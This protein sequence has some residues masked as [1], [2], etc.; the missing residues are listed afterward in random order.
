LTRAAEVVESGRFTPHALD[1]DAIAA[2]DDPL[3]RL[4]AVF[5]GMAEEIYARERRLQRNLRTLQ[6]SLLVL[7]VGA[8]WGLA[9]ALSRMA[10]GLGSNPLGLAVWVNAI[11]AAICLAIAAWRGSLP[12]PSWR[13]AC[14]ILFWSV[15]AGIL[16]RLTT[17]WVSAHVE[18]TYLSLIVTLEG[19]MVFAFAALM[20]LERASGRRLAGLLV[21][22]VGVTFVILTREPLGAASSLVWMLAALLLPFLFAVESIFMAARRP[23]GLDLIASV[24]IMMATSAAFLFPIALATGNLLLLGPQFGRLEMLVLL[25]G[26]GSATSLVLAFYLVTTAGAVFASQSAY[27]MTIAGIIW[28][29]LLLGE[30]LSVVAWAALGLILVGLYL[31]EPKSADERIT[32]DL[33]RKDRLSAEYG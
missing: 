23:E 11:A 2:G 16:Q 21:G 27:A 3:G 13:L 15:N 12:H 10:S 33:G 29:M 19:F 1:L 6:G 28:G 26:I 31:V 30:E 14:F 25:M 20:R 4:A 7:A 17:F 22:L 9:P 24:G 32:L 5:R 18:A 8:V